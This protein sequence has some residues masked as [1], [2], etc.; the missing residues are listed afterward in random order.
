MLKGQ[1]KMSAEKRLTIMNSEGENEVT[2]PETL[3]E[4]MKRLIDIAKAGEGLESIRKCSQNFRIFKTFV[5]CCLIHFTTST[6]WRYK[7][8]SVVISDIFT[9]SD[10]ALCILLME[11]NAD[12]FTKAYHEQRKIGRKEARPRY[13]KNESVDKTFKGWD[14]RGIRRFNIIVQAVKMNRE[15]NESKEMEMQLKSRYTEIAGRGM[16]SDNEESDN[17]DSELED[18]NGYDGFAGVTEEDISSNENDINNSQL[19]GITNITGV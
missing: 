9:E 2:E 18:L 3:K 10:E 19:S 5:S 16:I 14:K 8:T 11:N 12:D 1:A 6:N 4:D 13:T 17:D 7:A 15:L